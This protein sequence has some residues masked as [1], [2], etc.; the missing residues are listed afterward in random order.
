MMR[1]ATSVVF[2]L[3]IG[4]GG[5]AAAESLSGRGEIANLEPGQSRSLDDSPCLRVWPGI[6]IR[7]RFRLNE[8]REGVQNLVAKDGEYI[9]RVNGTQEG[10]AL[11]FFVQTDGKWE[12]RLLGPVI[13]AGAWY[14]VRAAWPGTG[15]ILEVNGTVYHS[16][17][18]G[19]VRAGEKP[20][21]AGPVAGNL[22]HLSIHNPAYD[23]GVALAERSKQ[24]EGAADRCEF[25]AQAGWAGWTGASGLVFDGRAG[26][27]AAAFA[28]GGAMLVSPP[29][30]TDIASRPFVCLDVDA[31]GPGWTGYL[32]FVTDSGQG[33]IPFVP[34]SGGRTTLITATACDA[35][36]GKLQRLALSFQGGKG[37]VSIKRL[38]FS[39]QPV[40]VPWF[41]IQ[42]FAPGR[43]K[44]RPGREE[45]VIAGIKNLGGEAEN[46][47]V[48]LEAPGSIEIL[49]PAERVVPYLGK[50]DFELITWKI[51]APHPGGGKVRVKVSGSGAE[52]HE[53][54]LAL[55]FEALPELPRTNYVPEPVPAR[56]DYVGL[57][58]YCALWKEG[59]H[60]GW[61]RI[62]PWPGRRPAIGWY[63]E[64]TPEVADWHIKYALE[65]GISGFIYCWYRAHLEPK[66]EHTLGHAIHDG[67]L[68]AKY[69]DRFKFS[70]MW[71]NGCAVGVKD[72][73]DLLDNVLPYWIENYFK[74]PCYLK[75]D[76]MP[77]LF[78]WQPRR[79]IPQLGGAEGAKQAL[80]LARARCRE[81][82][83]AGLRWVAC[84]DGADEKLGR[85][86]EASGWDAV[87]GYIVDTHK[88]PL[89]GIDPDGIPFRDYGQ[90]T[91]SYRDTWTARDA[92]T[93]SVPDI[94][95]VV[96]G[97]DPRPW[98]RGGE[99]G[100]LEPARAADF[101]AACRD[102]KAQ[103][104]AKPAGRWDRN[105][106]VFD[107]W[108]EFGEGHYIEPTS[109]L[110]FSYVNAIKR[111]FCREWAA[112]A[113]TDVIPE[114]LGLVPPQARYAAVR[115][116]FGPRLPWQPVRIQGDL[117]GWWQFDAEQN[118]S[119]P[120][121]SPNQIPLKP[122]N[123]RLEP[124]RKGMALRCGDG[125]ALSQV[126]GAFF[127][128]G[129]VTVALWCKPSE[130]QQSDH[131]LV[132][133]VSD[134]SAGYRLGLSGG[135]PSWQ[136]P[137]E[138]WSHGLTGPEALPVNEWSHVAATVDQR[139]MR[140]FVN[141]REVATLERRG[142]VKPGR[143]LVVGGY[144][145]DLER[146]RFR[147]WLDDVR[148]YRR[149]LADQEI[150]ELVKPDADKEIGRVGK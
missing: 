82:G 118:G 149:P 42:D 15:M 40:G 26:A 77:V 85:D 16:R 100:Y 41:Y 21:I 80:E 28:T 50:D 8:L 125:A 49:G 138:S 69:R 120:D 61:K 104:D 132:N 22:E 124:G 24:T 137:L 30:A 56:T 99:Y 17:R 117:L 23:R 64:G 11:A 73:A 27:L 135:K 38:V 128:P 46:I 90:A 71:E 55:E 52:T 107:N 78:V 43:A 63:D 66:I 12:P 79:L 54:E 88:I 150:A 75:V 144:G 97:W 141:G 136:V 147:G 87:T 126:P 127:N 44:L 19:A 37:S 65:H 60:Q 142:L 36:L 25:G 89:A 70:I 67:L 6:E 119:Y 140:L 20:L 98:H 114:D 68:Q 3:S 39:G 7:C 47:A 18:Q 4:I 83:F 143:E 112:E 133:T 116:G 96:M 146:A 48:K 14:E 33:T 131:W 59:T 94:P 105:L 108:T 92:C 148:L 95:N 2:L 109:G 129:G 35:W 113:V 139:M 74:Q 115:A 9:L 34:Q 123:V 102:A 72:S 81:A 103:V 122:V 91:R 111:V 93:G 106:V 134:G 62:E 86:I 110:G 32:D 84:M 5:L 121:S 57:M 53:R 31:P 76:N 58:H 13:Q 145:A 51:R 10:G 45:T 130:G 101:E 29:L 1:W